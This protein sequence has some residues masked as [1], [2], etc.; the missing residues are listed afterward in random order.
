M[1]EQKSPPTQRQVAL[2]DYSSSSSSSLEEMEIENKVTTER[3]TTE[4]NKG[5]PIPT[6]V[7]TGTERMKTKERIPN[8]FTREESEPGRTP[9]KP[10]ISPP[11]QPTNDL[12]GV[13]E[14]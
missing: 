3:Q 14:E 10:P 5:Q 13:M 12:E 1:G 11:T 8:P 4:E 6:I 2:T 7:S 9:L